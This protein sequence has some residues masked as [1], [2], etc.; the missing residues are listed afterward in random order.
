MS[1]GEETVIMGWMGGSG[2]VARDGQVPGGV[3]RV[4]VL[5]ATLVMEL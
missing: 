5:C 1:R 4:G 3:R 2:E